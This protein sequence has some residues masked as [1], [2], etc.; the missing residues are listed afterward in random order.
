MSSLV[1]FAS[2]P[3]GGVGGGFF[4]LEMYPKVYTHLE[5]ITPLRKGVACAS[6]STLNS[7]TV[8]FRICQITRGKDSRYL[9]LSDNQ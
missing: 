5:W 1:L 7:K 4:S 2:P 8:V 3:F 6:G 9:Y